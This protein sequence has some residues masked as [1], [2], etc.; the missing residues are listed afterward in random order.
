MKTSL[1]RIATLL[2][3]CSSF[4]FAQRIEISPLVSYPRWSR[5]ALGSLNETN[6][7]DTD[8][9]L[10]GKMGYGVRLTWNTKGYYGHE[11]GY[12][13]N[14]ADFRTDIATTS[15]DGKT[16]TR[17]RKTSE[18]KIQQ[19]F[20]NFMIY[21]MPAGERIRPFITGGAQAYQYG[22]P[23]IAE[24][25]RGTQRTYGA[26]FGGGVKFK[27]ME[28]LNVRLDFRDYIGG[29]PYDLKYADDTKF[30]GGMFQQLEGS[31]GISITF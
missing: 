11:I 19:A 4:A 10:R 16:V 30:G 8:T 1:L 25:S 22:A 28:H 31:V 6:N 26:N 9:Q 27:L 15:A 12:I 23:K 29:T 13:L 21:M 2:C 7:K 24:Y 3:L 17:A 14:T 5:K 18:V 20:Y